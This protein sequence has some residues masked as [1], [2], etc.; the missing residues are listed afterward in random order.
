MNLDKLQES[1]GAAAGAHEGMRKAYA[2]E[3]DAQARALHSLVEAVRPALPALV[4]PMKIDIVGCEVV[5]GSYYRL[6]PPKQQGDRW[7]PSLYLDAHGTLWWSNP[8]GK[9]W[10][11]VTPDEAAQAA[12]WPIEGW[13]G[14]LALSCEAAAK[15][16]AVKGKEAAERRASKLWALHVL[17]EK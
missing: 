10:E 9:R 8:E 16:R 4:S 3:R 12:V 11:Q 15:G 7:V 1:A 6:G 17:L 5:S 13:V 14:Q 2:E